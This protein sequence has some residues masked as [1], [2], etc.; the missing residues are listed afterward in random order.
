MANIPSQEKRIHRAERERLENRRR[1][2]Q[3]K[4]WFR[5]L[6]NAVSD[7]DSG[8]TDEEFRS[9]TSRIDK[10]VKSGAMH[11]NSGARKKSRAARLRSR[12]S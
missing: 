7:G 6:E 9:L 5:R 4:T 1:T 10:A 2:S 3:V 11:R 12:L 8:R